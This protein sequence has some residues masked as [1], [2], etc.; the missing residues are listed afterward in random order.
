MPYQH[1]SLICYLNLGINL[2]W[3]KYI[4]VCITKCMHWSHVDYIMIMQVLK[5]VT[6]G[7][8]S[9]LC[10]VSSSSMGSK[11]INYVMRQLG[12][13]ICRNP[14][15]LKATAQKQLKISLQNGKGKGLSFVPLGMQ[16]WKGFP[17]VYTSHAQ[18]G[19]IGLIQ[20]NALL[21]K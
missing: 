17:S 13:A 18:V 14:H 9:N 8:G 16:C 6:A 15:L 20:T 1:K 5:E 3:P 11:E 4:F 10:G 2:E 12:P 19:N 21:V 7:V